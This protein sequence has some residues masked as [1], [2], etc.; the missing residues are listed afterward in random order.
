MTNLVAR[1][2]LELENT[3]EFIKRYNIGETGSFFDVL[4][5]EILYNI[6]T[7]SVKGKKYEMNC[8]MCLVSKKFDLFIIDIISKWINTKY[9][10]QFQALEKIDHWMEKILSFGFISTHRE[11]ILT[12]LHHVRKRGSIKLDNNFVTFE[13]YKGGKKHSFIL[14]NEIYYYRNE[15]MMI[16]S[17][18]RD[19]N[20]TI[21]IKD[22]NLEKYKITQYND[23]NQTWIYTSDYS[24]MIVKHYTVELVCGNY[25]SMGSKAEYEPLQFGGYTFWIPRDKNIREYKL[26]F[27]EKSPLPVTIL[28][29]F[30]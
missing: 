3:K 30:M 10:K 5:D 11:L 9:H 15:D 20:K 7:Y 2:T 29:H 6:L 1:L 25:S 27:S 23:V 24:T 19:V 21:T 8:K 4:P 26:I 18:N 22:Y 28:K 13:F 14:S 12:I 16:F 17:A